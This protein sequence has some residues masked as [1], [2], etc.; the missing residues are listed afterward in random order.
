MDQHDKWVVTAFV[1]GVIAVCIMIATITVASFVTN[2][3][4]QQACIDAGGSWTTSAGTVGKSCLI[5]K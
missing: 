5:N 3:S 4:T 2:S 1:V